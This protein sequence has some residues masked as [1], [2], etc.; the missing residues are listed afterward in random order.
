VKYLNFHNSSF[1]FKILFNDKFGNAPRC[2]THPSLYFFRAA[3][4]VVVFRSDLFALD[5]ATVGFL[6]R[7]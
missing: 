5:I 7:K 2:V 1:A 4:V 6:G 3:L